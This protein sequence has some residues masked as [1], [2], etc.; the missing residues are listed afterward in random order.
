MWRWGSSDALWVGIDDPLSKPDCSFLQRRTIWHQTCFYLDSTV[1][2]IC[3]TQTIQLC[4]TVRVS[5][6]LKSF[7]VLEHSAARIPFNLMHS[8]SERAC[9]V[10]L[11]NEAVKKSCADGLGQSLIRYL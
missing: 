8:N 1:A 10:M 2:T 9:P 11:P 4:G 7:I 6:Q 5:C 3:H